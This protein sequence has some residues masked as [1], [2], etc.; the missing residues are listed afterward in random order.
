MT[1]KL[2]CNNP[3]PPK[4][5]YGKD[6]VNVAG[7]KMIP[8]AQ[9]NLLRERAVADEYGMSE[10]ER[11]QLPKVLVDRTDAVAYCMRLTRRLWRRG[12]CP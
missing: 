2:V 8:E 12:S 9:Q 7:M 4:V 1:L 5:T 10:E 11:A 3:K 6:F